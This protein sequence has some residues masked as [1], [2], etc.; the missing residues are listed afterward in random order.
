MSLDRMV[1][2]KIIIINSK[3]KKFMKIELQD[4]VQLVGK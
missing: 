1:F 4:K 3:R 2:L